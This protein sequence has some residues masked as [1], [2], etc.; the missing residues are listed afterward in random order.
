MNSSRH[1][2]WIIALSAM[3][4]LSLA[5]NGYLSFQW[6]VGELKFKTMND[7]KAKSL[8]N[9]L[10]TMERENRQLQETVE[11]TAK[12]AM[13]PKEMIAWLNREV[14]TE[15]IEDARFTYLLE[16]PI[17][18][19]GAIVANWTMIGQGSLNARRLFG[20]GI[21]AYYRRVNALLE[22]KGLVIQ[23]NFFGNGSPRW[24]QATNTITWQQPLVFG[25]RK[26]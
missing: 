14:A 6:M 26:R 12:L 15:V 13:T 22:P 10:D 19:K 2:G 3:L 7:A 9:Q 23:Q 11:R 4:F 16:V 24:D 21:A 1:R 5:A 25:P 20:D 8:Q 17:E 18:S